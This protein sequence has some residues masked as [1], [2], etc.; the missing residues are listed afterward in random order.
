MGN[1]L[2]NNWGST[3]T[4][5]IKS[6]TLINCLPMKRKIILPLFI[7]LLT[8]IQ[9]AG[10]QSD[11]NSSKKHTDSLENLA[12]E[13]LKKFIAADT[14]NL[15]L[16][17]AEKNSINH[18]GEQHLMVVPMNRGSGNEQNDYSSWDKWLPTVYHKEA[19]VGSPFLLFSYV[20]GLVVRDSWSVVDKPDYLYNYDKMS[21][22]LLLIR[23][24]ESPIAV[25]ISQVKL[26]CLKADKGGLIFKRVPFINSGEFYQVIYKG[27]HYSCY[28]LYKSIFIG[29]NQTSNGY[30]QEG[31]D[32]DEYED[33][34][35]Y[36]LADEKKEEFQ[37]FELKKKS[38]KLVFGSVSPATES[39]M[40]VHKYEDVNETFLANLTAELNK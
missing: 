10:Q 14:F 13:Q 36:Y 18:A 23:N 21:G 1:K 2:N 30:V 6:V 29:A 22:N 20:P 5:R 26:F 11:N 39:Y 17:E 32:Y 38:I 35:T 34:I 12:I 33:V 24:N 19:T 9:A 37:I 25:N 31:K 4:T 16:A 27:R 40:K 8:I 15:G 3:G 7:S 28:K